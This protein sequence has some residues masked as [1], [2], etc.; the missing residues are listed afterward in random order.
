[1]N[2][3]TK[4]LKKFIQEEVHDALININDN[5]YQVQAHL[6]EIEDDILDPEYFIKKTMELE[7]S[8]RRK[9]I[10]VD[11]IAETPNETWE[12]CKEKAKM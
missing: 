9:N 5:I 10:R 3:L 2:V 6:Q 12:S 7:E 8:S 11:A 1:M 4:Y